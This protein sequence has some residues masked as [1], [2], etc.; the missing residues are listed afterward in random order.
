MR[1]VFACEGWTGQQSQGGP[2]RWQCQPEDS[3]SS[4]TFN[5]YLWSERWSGG[6]IEHTQFSTYRCIAHWNKSTQGWMIFNS[7]TMLAEFD[8]HI[9]LWLNLFTFGLLAALN[10]IEL[11]LRMFPR[12]EFQAEELVESSRGCRM[13]WAE[14]APACRSPSPEETMV[15]I[16]S[17]FS[18]SSQPTRNTI[19]NYN[20]NE[21]MNTRELLICCIIHLWQKDS[22][23]IKSRAQLLM[24]NIYIY[25]DIQ[26]LLPEV[27]ISGY[28]GEIFIARH[29]HLCGG[30]VS[31][32]IS[33]YNMAQV[34]FIGRG[35]VPAPY[36][37]RSQIA[38]FR[39]SPWRF[40]GFW[41]K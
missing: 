11:K 22:Q 41:K 29:I 34:G 38:Y 7:D 26:S 8:I 18:I 33:W 27:S 4:S 31:S 5:F 19:G 25:Q 15:K 14:P 20:L 40:P 10:T 35:F 6:G 32:N 30:F 36:R 39:T 13:G 17:A 23:L 24:N 12:A 1:E 37:A 9:S 2:S 3:S 28:P 21:H 16:A